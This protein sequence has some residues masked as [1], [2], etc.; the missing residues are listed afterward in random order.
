MITQVSI[1]NYKSLANVEVELDP[2][3]V[4]VGPNGSGKSNFV[5][6]LRFVS[7]AVS[8]NL[9]KAVIRRDGIDTIKCATNEEQTDEISFDITLQFGEDPGKFCF[10]IV[11]EKNWELRVTSEQALIAE[12]GYTIKEGNIKFSDNETDVTA[13]LLQLLYAYYK[14]SE[15]ARLQL[16][17]RNS[18]FLPL[19][20]LFASI[21]KIQHYLRDVGYYSIFPNRSLRQPQK[22]QSRDK[23]TSNGNNLNSVLQRLKEDA[24]EQFERLRATLGKMV[25]GVTDIIVEEVGGYLA[26]KLIY[27]YGDRTQGFYLGQESDGTLRLLGILTALY[28]QPAPSLITIEEPELAVHP[29][30]LQTLYEVIKEASERS[31]IIITTHSPD[32]IALCDPDDLRI[33]EKDESGATRIARLEKRQI[34][35]I[36]EKLFKSSDL[37]RIEGLRPESPTQ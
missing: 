32:L 31:Q 19:G 2:L 3:T 35:I 4:L 29:G 22:P 9:E 30:A 16:S 25:P 10:D 26:V 15:D 37:L 23:L 8:N 14:N 34:E 36:Q 5:D 12:E 11:A 7:E 13:R 28:Q 27:Q 21:E 24:E 20:S 6:A 1:R 17:D 18:L 33:V